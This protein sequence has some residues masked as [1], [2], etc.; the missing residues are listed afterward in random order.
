MRSWVATTTVRT[1]AAAA[2]RSYRVARSPAAV[3]DPIGLIVIQPDADAHTAIVPIS[4]SS[5]GAAG[6][7][8]CEQPDHD[9]DRRPAYA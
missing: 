2:N 1:I 7:Q 5:H 4:P 3:V 8:D 6:R 9:S